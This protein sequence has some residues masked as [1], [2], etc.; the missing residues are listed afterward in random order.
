MAH[1]S[2][3]TADYYQLLGIDP[4]AGA[5]EIRQAYLDK[6]RQWHPDRNPDCIAEAEEK[7][8]LLN[9]AFFVL[10]D[11]DRRKNYD[12]M[13]RFTR[14]KNFTAD[15]ND[16]AIRKKLNRV[17]PAM[18]QVLEQVRTLYAL[19]RDAVRGDFGLHPANVALIGGGLL[20][21]LLP[22]DLVPDFIPLAG[23]IDDLAVLTT[24]AGSLKVEIDRHRA[25]TKTRNP[26][27]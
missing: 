2:E 13:L 20:Y 4:Q 18:K 1:G 21:F 26:G 12:R 24:I 22:V 15:I 10:R 16:E 23:Y 6:I 19:F 8:K 9:Q 3:K 27:G 5:E 7:T 11:A 14:G 17:Y 25:W